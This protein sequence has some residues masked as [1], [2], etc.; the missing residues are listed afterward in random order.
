MWEYVLHCVI[1]TP[2]VW[3]LK[4]YLHLLEL[5]FGTYTVGQLGKNNEQQNNR[6][7]SKKSQLVTSYIKVLGVLD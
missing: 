1:K 5:R 4:L 7:D 2:I 3:R 6:N